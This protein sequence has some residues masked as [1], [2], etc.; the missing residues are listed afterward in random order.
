MNRISEDLYPMRVNPKNFSRGDVVKKIITDT[1]QTPYVGVVT[2]P[3]PSTNK[4]EV[5]WPHSMGMEDP[6]DL[7]KVNPVI[8]PPVVNEDKSYPSYQNL[9]QVKEYQKKLQH[10]NILEDFISEHILPITV[11]ASA[12]YN[13]SY[14]K[15]EAYKKLSKKFDAGD[16]LMNV[17]N[18]IYS[19]SYNTRIAK[20]VLD[21]DEYKYAQ[22]ILKGNCDTG[23]EVSYSLDDSS[24]KKHYDS[25]VTAVRAFINIKKIVDSDNS[26][27]ITKV[28]KIMGK[29]IKG[30]N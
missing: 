10:H 24:I 14:S 22:L 13:D 28:S 20:D 15:V 2:R 12:L 26:Q 23:F 4:V 19:D 9:T 30:D 25:P 18:K 11:L 8:N 1:I 21:K 29:G 17:L 3:I 5:Q 6:W 27:N 16:I 7:I